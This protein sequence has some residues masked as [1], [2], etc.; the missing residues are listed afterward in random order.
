M[1]LIKKISPPRL[2]KM[3]L[4]TTTKFHGILHLADDI[5]AYGVPLEVDTASK[6]EHHKPSK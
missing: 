4:N 1:Q 3:G 2:E 5:L 6:E